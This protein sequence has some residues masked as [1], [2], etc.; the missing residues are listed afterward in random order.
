MQLEGQARASVRAMARRS[1]ATSAGS[2][3]WVAGGISATH[4]TAGR[5]DRDR[6][7][8]SPGH[9]LE[10]P[11]AGGVSRPRP[12]SGSAARNAP[13]TD[14]RAV[15]DSL[16][17]QPSRQ[18]REQCC[19]AADWERTARILPH[20]PL[21]AGYLTGNFDV[22]QRLGG[23]VHRHDGPAHQPVV[24]RDAR[25]PGKARHTAT[26]P[27]SNCRASSTSSSRSG[28][29]SVDLALEAGLD[30]AHVPLIFPTSDD[31]QAGLVGGGAVDAGQMA[32]ILGNSAVV[33]SSSASLPALGQTSTRCG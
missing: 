8:G 20:G 16:H 33:N 10:R 13:R 3:H 29:C 22:S 31:Q 23:G 1:C 28:R 14:R 24:P 9:L 11:H 4:H 26:S 6:V 17:A 15:G 12:A 25:R 7:P 2:R 5:I 32:I 19:R 30:A 18:G 21:A 27:G